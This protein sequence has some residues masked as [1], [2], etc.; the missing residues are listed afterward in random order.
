MTDC[1]KHSSL[2]RHGINTSV[3]SFMLH[4]PGTIF[5]KKYG[6]IMDILRNKLVSLLL[7]VAITRSDK[8]P[9]LLSNL[10]HKTFCSCNCSCNCSRNKLKCLPLVFHF[11]PSEI[12]AGKARAYQS[13]APSIDSP[14][15]LITNIKLEWK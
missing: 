8:H 10:Y 6:F 3:K 14:L 11:H 5:I 15:P 9:N 4:N 13:V 12:F 7:S 2:L 1:D